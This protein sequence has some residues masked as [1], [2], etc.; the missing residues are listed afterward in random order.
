MVAQGG[1]GS[2]FEKG[3]DDSAATHEGGGVEGGVTIAVGL[4]DVC[5]VLEKKG[6]NFRMSMKRCARERR[7]AIFLMESID[8]SAE[9]EL[10]FDPRETAAGDGSFEKVSELVGVAS[11]RVFD[12]FCF[13]GNVENEVV[14]E[15]SLGVLDLKKVKAVAGK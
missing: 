1:G 9:L 7:H 11:G 13:F 5:L 14:T 15:E 2:V 6:N 4:F 12:V 8:G 10:P 3:F